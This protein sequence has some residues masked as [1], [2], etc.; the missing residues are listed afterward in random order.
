MIFNTLYDFQIDKPVK[1]LEEVVDVLELVPTKKTLDLKE[2]QEEI[3][4]AIEVEQEEIEMIEVDKEK[5]KEKEFNVK[6]PAQTYYD[7]IAPSKRKE[8]AAQYTFIPSNVQVF[9]V[10]Q[11]MLG[12]NVLGCAFLGQNVIYIRDTLHGNE[13]EEVKRHEINHI[14]HPWM[15]ES[16]IRLKPKQELPF[17]ARFH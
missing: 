2:E 10:P 3:Q 9:R 4:R 1:K 5:E 15:T 13:F 11:T 8:L 17:D 14:L 7:Y 6:I 12:Y 16:Q